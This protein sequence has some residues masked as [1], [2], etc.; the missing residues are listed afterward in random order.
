MSDAFLHF[1]FV[2]GNERVSRVIRAAEMGFAYSHVGVVM[3]DGFSLF[4]AHMQGGVAIRDAESENPWNAWAYVSVPCTQAQ[5][6]EFWT[7]ARAQIGKAY[8]M[9]AIWDMAGSVLEAKQGQ[10]FDPDA[11][12]CSE[13]QLGG[14]RA[15]GFFDLWIPAPLRTVTPEN[16]MYLLCGIPGS[17]MTIRNLPDTAISGG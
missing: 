9:G 17:V 12:F 3:P 2:T 11:W 13:L 10:S 14:M 4:S 5:Y 16:F 15:A 8:D 6:D 7:F 1:Y